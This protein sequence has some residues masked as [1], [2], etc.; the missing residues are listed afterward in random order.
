LFRTKPWIL[1]SIYIVLDRKKAWEDR[2]E[3]V[4]HVSTSC[5][6]EKELLRGSPELLTDWWYV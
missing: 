6:W 1:N 5:I 4:Q 3:M 2:W